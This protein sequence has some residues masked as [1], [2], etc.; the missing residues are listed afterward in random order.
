MMTQVFLSTNG[1]LGKSVCSHRAA[2]QTIDSVI[3]ARKC[4]CLILILPLGGANVKNVEIVGFIFFHLVAPKDRTLTELDGE[5]TLLDLKCFFAVN[6]YVSLVH[7]V[8]S[9]QLFHTV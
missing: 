4:H 9:V 3:V 1:K 5:A 6:L 2:F 7:A 8:K